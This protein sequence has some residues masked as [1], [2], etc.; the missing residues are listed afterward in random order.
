M[1]G[2]GK[3]IVCNKFDCYSLPES[4]SVLLALF[5]RSSTSRSFREILVSSH[6]DITGTP[7][8]V[9]ARERR[10]PESLQTVNVSPTEEG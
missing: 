3:R 6:Q 10:N 5:F 4:G 8:I 1:D 9:M 7:T 2:C